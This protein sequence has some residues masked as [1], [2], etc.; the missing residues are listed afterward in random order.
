MSPSQVDRFSKA[1]TTIGGL[2]RARK[3]FEIDLSNLKA[4]GMEKI[5]IRRYKQLW[6]F[7]GFNFEMFSRKLAKN[8]QLFKEKSV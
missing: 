2:A 7:M 6:I 3:K 8:V 4:S 5:Q 1:T